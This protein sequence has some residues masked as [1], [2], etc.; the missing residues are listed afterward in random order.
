MFGCSALIAQD[1]R[2][3]MNKPA[4]PVK[5]TYVP[6]DALAKLTKQ[7]GSSLY[8]ITCI[9]GKDGNNEYWIRT[10]SGMKISEARLSESDVYAMK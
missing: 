3:G 9:K 5:E 1:K 4:L 2:I 6:D 10:K 7:Y 8:S